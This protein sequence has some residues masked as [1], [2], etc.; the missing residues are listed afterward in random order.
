MSRHVME[1]CLWKRHISDKG[2]MS[3]NSI[4][5]DMSSIYGHV[6]DMKKDSPNGFVM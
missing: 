4:S 5:V 6:L 2:D 3:I 1:P